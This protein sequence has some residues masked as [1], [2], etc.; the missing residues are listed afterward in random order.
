[1]VVV[2]GA[3]A[4]VAFFAS[5]GEEPIFARIRQKHDEAGH[6]KRVQLVSAELA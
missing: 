1:V 3:Q 4:A 5:R 6:G 2:S